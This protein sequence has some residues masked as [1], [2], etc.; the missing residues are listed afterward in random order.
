MF[1]FICQELQLYPTPS[2]APIGRQDCLV[3][4]PSAWVVSSSNELL[5]IVAGERLLVICLFEGACGRGMPIFNIKSTRKTNIPIVVALINVGEVRVPDLWRYRGD[6]LLERNDA[7]TIWD[8]SAWHPYSCATSSSHVVREQGTSAASTTAPASSTRTSSAPARAEIPIGKLLLDRD[9]K[10]LYWGYVSDG[11]SPTRIGG[12]WCK[13]H[14]GHLRHD[15][16]L[17]GRKLIN[18]SGDFGG[19]G[20]RHSGVG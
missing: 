3:H 10:L 9:Y 6:G 18:R 1:T 12:G 5:C 7:T 15:R 19:D 2:S 20:R 4:P 11:S 17:V 14:R 16:R 8:K 13:R